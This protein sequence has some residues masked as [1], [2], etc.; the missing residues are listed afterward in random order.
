M[1]AQCE[2]ARLNG[3]PLHEVGR[4]KMMF[5]APLRLSFP[6]LVPP[7]L[8]DQGYKRSEVSTYPLEMAWAWYRDPVA[9][10]ALRKRYAE[11]ASRNGRHLLKYGS[12]VPAGE[13][14]VSPGSVDMSGAGLAILRQNHAEGPCAMVEYG[15]HGGGHG[16]P[17]KLQLIL[18]GL[19]QPLCPDLGTTGYGVPLHSQWYK[20]TPGHNTVTIGA[21]NQKATTGKLL[22]FEA[23]D[24]FS[25]TAVESAQAYS[26]WDLRRH[27]LLTDDFLVDVFDVTGKEADTVDWFLHPT[28]QATPSLDLEP[29][30][31][32]AE[33]KTYA[34][35]KEMRSGTTGDAWS[36]AWTTD[37]GTMHLTMAGEAG[38]RVTLA[39]AP[40]PAGDDPWDT[41][42]V[43]RETKATRFVAVY[44]FLKPGVKP[45]AVQ[46]VGGS[47]RIGPATVSL[48]TKDNPL[49]ALR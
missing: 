35:L 44:Q 26:G 36:C 48:P 16:H 43:R 5:T 49:P 4:M 37:R 30:G 9:A 14:Y 38:T 8:N 3:D 29:D 22:A 21:R 6:N 15:E 28:G 25:A 1:V 7:S 24:G 18:Y 41:L 32:K 12:D 20:T 31:A 23:G 11:G 2:A 39:K 19:G 10:S 42:R 33:S 27:L 40:G 45:E 34:Y 47:L 17:D 13:E 46:R